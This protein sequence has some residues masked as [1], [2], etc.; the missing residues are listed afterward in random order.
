MQFELTIL[1]CSSATPTHERHPSAQLLNISGRFYLIDCGEGTQI[2]FL[3]YKIKFL[4]INH[5]FISHLHG[6]HFFGLVGL[7][8]T[9]HLNG[10]TKPLKIFGH[11]GLKEILDIQFGYSSTTLNFPINFF[12]ID[13]SGSM[14]IHEDDLVTV[15]TIPLNHRIPCMGFLFKEKQRERSLKMEVVGPLKIP[16]EYYPAIKKGYDYTTEKGEKISNES[17]TEQPPIPRSFAYCSDTAYHEPVLQYI[18][19][20]DLLYHEATFLHDLKE[21][22]DKTF[23]ST[24]KEAGIIARKGRVKQLVIGHFSTRYKDAGVLAQEAKFEFNNTEL[25]EEGRVYRIG[26]D[27]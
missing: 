18:E 19:G 17:I 21:R 12:P 9:M 27:N 8:S 2:Q 4:S 5:I 25:A 23:H 11:P 14:V 26:V 16:F 3:K 10:R 1:G 13:Y 24:A 22:A 6:D 7:I 15:S 20:V